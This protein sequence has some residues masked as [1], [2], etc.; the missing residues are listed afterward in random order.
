MADWSL[1]KTTTMTVQFLAAFAEHS[2]KETSLINEL[3]QRLRESCSDTDAVAELE[4]SMTKRFKFEDTWIS[5]FLKLF[6]A[7]NLKENQA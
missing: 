3:L 2:I 7:L 5:N 1:T 4:Y 6:K